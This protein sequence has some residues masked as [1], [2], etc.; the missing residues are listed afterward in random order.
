MVE[1]WMSVMTSTSAVLG[2]AGAVT[3]CIWPVYQLT[4]SRA[5]KFDEDIETGLAS[6]RS[7]LRRKQ[8]E[9]DELCATI[10]DPVV[11]A[12]G[13]GSA[14]DD[15][16]RADISED[17]LRPLRAP[18]VTAFTALAQRDRAAGDVASLRR[19]RVAAWGAAGAA[20]AYGDSTQQLA[21]IEQAL[22]DANSGE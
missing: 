11:F 6:F 19:A 8:A 16:G 10:P 21:E 12:Q 3:T 1:G 15:A 7:A 17:Y 4:K 13:M 14:K 20:G 2:F 5:A 9:R 18:L 22:G